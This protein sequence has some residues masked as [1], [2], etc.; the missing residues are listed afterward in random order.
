MEEYAPG[1]LGGAAQ[2]LP[3]TQR[4]RPRRDDSRVPGVDEALQDA[5]DSRLPDGHRDVKE[6]TRRAAGLDLSGSVR[7]FEVLVGYEDTEI[8]KPDAGPVLEAASRFGVPAE[9][10]L[11]CGDSPH[12]MDAGIAA[13][14]V[15]AAA[16]WGPF[17][18]R[19]LE[20][21]PGLRARNAERSGRSARRQRASVPTRKSS[22]ETAFVRHTYTGGCGTMQGVYS[23]ER[24]GAPLTWVSRRRSTCPRGPRSFL[25]WSCWWS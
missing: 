15:T 11:Y 2:R 25:P 23:G 10:C 14:A 4:A 9:Q 6:Q 1:P 3:R 20:P 12:D 19:V 24:R 21:G 13:G 5:L 17:A 16:L 8:H 22:G 18:E 7:Y